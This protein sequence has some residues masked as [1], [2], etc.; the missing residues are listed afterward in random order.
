MVMNRTL[1]EN[2]LKNV[3]IVAL[4]IPCYY[5]IE[6]Y[7]FYSGR[8]FDPTIVGNTLISVGILAVIACFGNFAFTYE[9]VHEADLQSRTL[10]H[11]TT[12]LLMLLIGVALELT[13]VL[14]RLLIGNFLVYDLS[15]FGLYL[16]SVLYD[17]WDLKRKH[18]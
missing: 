13:S 3:L 16:A 7:F 9:K 6:N 5:V 2:I 4:L 1:L 11:L 12:G 10:A 15:L 14:T 8:V 17:F 18:N